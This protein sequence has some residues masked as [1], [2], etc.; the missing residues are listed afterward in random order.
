MFTTQ[1][2]L[3]PAAIKP[4]DLFGFAV[5][6]I[7]NIMF[8]GAPAPGGV[9]Y[10]QIYSYNS[11]T[12]NEQQKLFASDFFSANIF[13]TAIAANSMANSLVIGASTAQTFGVKSGA[14]YYFA[15]NGDSFG[16]VQKL[17]PNS[18]SAANAGD[19]FGNAVVYF[20]NGQYDYFVVA[21][22]LS[23]STQEQVFTFGTEVIKA[24][25]SQ[26]Q[27]FAISYL[28]IFVTILL[29]LFFKL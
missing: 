6:L 28:M 21:S 9:G 12:W 23:S 22:E 15:N 24:C 27:S 7:N 3:Q 26:P 19:N 16:Q 5:E 13:G 14:I 2:R 29:S 11:G 18:S 1:I 20:P 8:V 17:Y 10:V 25:S 4:N